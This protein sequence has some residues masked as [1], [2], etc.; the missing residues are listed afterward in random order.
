[1]TLNRFYPCDGIIVTQDLCHVGK[2]SFFCT[3]SP[4]SVGVMPFFPDNL[5]ILWV[6]TSSSPL[7]VMRGHDSTVYTAVFSNVF[8]TDGSGVARTQSV[9]LSGGMDQVVSFEICLT[10]VK[11]AACSSLMVSQIK[12]WNADEDNVGAFLGEFPSGTNR[13][14]CMF[15]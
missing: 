8:F 12:I 9:I 1:M 11:H 14:V 2:A 6:P 3:F 5:V 10:F 15:V 13:Y 7:M 4:R